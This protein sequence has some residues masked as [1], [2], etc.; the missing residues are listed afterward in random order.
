LFQVPSAGKFFSGESSALCV[1]VDGFCGCRAPLEGVV[2]ATISALGLLVKI[3]DFVVSMMVTLHCVV[4]FL[5]AL[6]WILSLFFLF[7]IF[8]GKLVGFFL[9]S[10]FFNLVRG[11]LITLYRFGRW[12]LFIKRC[13]SLF[14]YELIVVHHQ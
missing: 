6:S 12:A 14:C 1:N 10:N 8:G 7:H 5:G 2:A 3:Q 4:S 9:P 11:S 13:E